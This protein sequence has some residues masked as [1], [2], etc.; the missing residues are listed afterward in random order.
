MPLNRRHLLACASAAAWIPASRAAAAV[1]LLEWLRSPT[2]VASVRQRMQQAQVPGLALA[3][4]EGGQVLHATAFGWADLAA[5]RPMAADTLLNIA[6]VTKV[7]TCAAVLQWHERG[8]LDLD[9]PLD[10]H[11]PFEMR[12][13]SGAAVTARQLLTHTAA[14]AD[15]PA[16][17]A[18]YACGDPQTPLQAW[19]SQPGHVQFH[20]TPPGERHAYS[21]VGY[22]LLG[23]AVERLS[24]QPFPV[25]CEQALLAPLG[26][27]RSR[28]S[29][30]G[31]DRASHATPYEFVPAGKPLPT[32]LT[33]PEPPLEADGGAGQQVPLCLYSFATVSDGLLRSSVLELARFAR[34][35]LG[36][37]ELQGRRVLRAASVAEMLADQGAPVAER[38]GYR[39][40]LAWRGLGQGVWAHMGRDPGVAAALQIHPASGRG[41]VVLA[42]GSRARPLVGQLAAEVMARPA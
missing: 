7:F 12:H 2:Q 34:A 28:V 36:G 21:N 16:Y 24:G 37:G 22:G 32:A 10:A 39:Q 33:S 14:I 27:R 6:S 4:I 29:I 5:R 30:A 41:V 17:A 20:A 19:L 31:L 38:A 23:L 40:G 13:P 15:G 25:A 8:R 35:V 3:V 11:L 18:S 1:P 42:N 26:M 9:G